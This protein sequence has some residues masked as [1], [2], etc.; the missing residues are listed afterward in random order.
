M[1]KFELPKWAKSTRAWLALAVAVFAF[2]A[3]AAA[4][5]LQV[6]RW[7]WFSEHRRDVQII[8]STHR[9]D[10]KAITSKHDDDVMVLAGNVQKNKIAILESTQASVRR[11]L[12]NI[13]ITKRRLAQQG[14]FDP[15]LERDEQQ[16]QN[17]LRDINARL[18]RVRGH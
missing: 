12:I 10:V 16:L 13:R 14:D 8:T 3:G 6:P 15:Q 2:Y 7:A 11:Q 1:S 9:S 5:G 17:Q 18:K 4:V